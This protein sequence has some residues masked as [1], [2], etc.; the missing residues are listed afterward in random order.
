M[1]SAAPFESILGG[2]AMVN[3]ITVAR[4]NIALYEDWYNFQHLPERISTPGFLRARRFVAAQQLTPDASDYLTIYETV[5]PQVLASP[6]YLARLDNPTELT[7][8][9]VP[10][11]ASFRRAACRV[12]AVTGAGA[13]AR[14]LA[15]ELP[16]G[17]DAHAARDALRERV[18]PRLIASHL[19]HVGSLY[20]P[21]RAISAA[22]DQTAEGRDSRQQ[23]AAESLMLLL[24]LQAG[25]DSGSLAD[26]LVGDDDLL[27]ATGPADLASREFELLFELRARP[28]A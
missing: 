12:T 28:A 17:T 27:L 2:G 10:L 19:V 13:S 3:W 7:R 4:E 14:V 25:V 11:F 24:E 8:Q 22:K 16:Q 15:V 26:V 5:D 23:E 9:V 21:D 6:D 1:G 20:E 18:M